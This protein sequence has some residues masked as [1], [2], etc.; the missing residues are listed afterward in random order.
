MAEKEKAKMDTSKL[1]KD[2]RRS[3]FGPTDRCDSALYDAALEDDFAHGRR[4]DSFDE[5][6]DDNS[7]G[8]DDES[9]DEDS[10][11]SSEE[12]E[13]RLGNVDYSDEEDGSDNSEEEEDDE[14]ISSDDDGSSSSGSSHESD[15]N[16]SDE[17]SID[18]DDIEDESEELFPED[19][20][21]DN[22]IDQAE[23]DFFFEAAENEANNGLGPGAAGA[24]GGNDVMDE[25][26]WTRIDNGGRAAAAAGLGVT[27]NM[28]LDMVNNAGPGG[29]LG[30]GPPLQGLG[31][32]LPGGGNAANGGFLMDA[33]ESMLGNI[34]RGDLGLE[35]LSEIE[36]ALG[37]RLVRGG[38]RGGGL[39]GEMGNLTGLTNRNPGIS[40]GNSIGGWRPAIHVAQPN[41]RMLV[42]R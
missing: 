3:T 5:S 13:V 32:V 12:M 27:G 36:D 35:G 2:S 16:E 7:E 26:G 9:M 30:G 25:E 14:E 34:L 15:D 42:S 10:D 6:M 31:R 8:E 28:L 11:S 29:P 23:E 4:G 41:S 1:G 18:D 19:S 22:A 17:E 33:A 21:E 20:D 24:G 38:N 39:G 37:I 40:I